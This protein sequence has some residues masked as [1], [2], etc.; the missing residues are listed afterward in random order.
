M[1][2]SG[3]TLDGFVTDLRH[4]LAQVAS[5]ARKLDAG[6]AALARLL[7]NPDALTPYLGALHKDHGPWLLYEDAEYGFV[8]T[9]LL[10]PR[11]QTTPVH[12]HGEAWTLYGVLRG[13]ELIHRYE[14]YDDGSRAGHA[15][16]RPSVD[17]RRHPGQVEVEPP[18][19]IHNE[20]TDAGGDTVAIAVRGR[21]LATTEG[22]WFDLGRGT[23]EARLGKGARPIS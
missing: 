19:A 17:H 9:L 7:T 6:A 5:Q 2:G 4:A 18:Y 11:G 16:V 13:E 22:A 23:V 15:D 10:K 1:S 8:V 21:D 14:R 20:T 12:H 3:Y